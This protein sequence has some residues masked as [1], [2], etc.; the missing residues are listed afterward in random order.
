MGG[1]SSLCTLLQAA[2]GIWVHIYIQSAASFIHL[3]GMDPRIS[4]AYADLVGAG[5]PTMQF[6]QQEMAKVC[7]YVWIS[8]IQAAWKCPMF[9]V[10]TSV[11][12]KDRSRQHHRLQE[13]GLVLSSQQAHLGT[14]RI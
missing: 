11:E 12:V 14:R 9:S 6:L 3:K 1:R 4:D 7:P 5:G 8:T 10:R 13:H 2:R